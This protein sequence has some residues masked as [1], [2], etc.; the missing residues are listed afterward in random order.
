MTV[1]NGMIFNP[2]FTLL[3]DSPDE[4]HVLGPLQTRHSVVCYPQ[5]NVI[6]N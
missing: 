2:H 6:D 3:F 5:L 4:Y 1:L